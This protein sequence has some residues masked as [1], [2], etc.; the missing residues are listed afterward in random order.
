MAEAYQYGA[1]RD[2]ILMASGALS[3]SLALAL[4]ALETLPG[5]HGLA[6]MCNLD[7]VGLTCTVRETLL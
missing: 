3:W 4:S 7:P 1:C 2:L 6:N 5:W